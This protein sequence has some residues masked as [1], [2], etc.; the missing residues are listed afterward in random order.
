MKDEVM[1]GN[2][3]F[4]V[5]EEDKGLLRATAGAPDDPVANQHRKALAQVLRRAWRSGVLEPDQIEPIFDRIPL[6][7]GADARFP[8]DFYRPSDGWGEDETHKAFIVPKEGEIPEVAIEGEE[9]YV[10]TFKMAN[11]I[12]WAL[13]YARDGRWDVVSKAVEVFTN[14]FTQRL[15]DEGWKVILAAANS[16]GTVVTDTAAGAGA[17]TKAL[18]TEL[19][20]QIKRLAG[21]RGSRL[22]D[23]YLSPESVADIRNFNNTILD[24]ITL[25]NILITPEDGTP[26]MFGV[27]LHET[28][29]FG[30][31]QD[32]QNILVTDL[33]ASLGADQE[34]VVGLDLSNRDSFVMPIREEMQM[35]D[36]PAL[37]RK[38]RAGVYG[39]LEVGFASLD[40]RRAI[41]GSL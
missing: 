8:L 39:W 7:A 17:F 28:P 20:V 25:R 33:G 26:Q 24:D 2:K 19:M 3:R 40:N 5:T 29:D 31:G 37:H 16:H 30:V 32:Y 6:P 18:I 38:Q 22:T 12:D 4:R 14:G 27:R 36:D 13:D 10:P 34:F 1:L 21:G 9:I 35:F 11:A 41:L 15:N 23:I